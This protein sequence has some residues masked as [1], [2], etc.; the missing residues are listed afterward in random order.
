M[1]LLSV[2]FALYCV[3]KQEGKERKKQEKEEVGF[4]EEQE[5]FTLDSSRVPLLLFEEK[6]KELTE[7]SLSLGSLDLYNIL[8][9]LQVFWGSL[10]ASPADRLSAFP[11]LAKCVNKYPNNSKLETLLREG[12]GE[13]LPQ[14]G[15]ETE[16]EVRAAI[17]ELQGS[18]W[19][20]AFQTLSG[21]LLQ[22]IT[23]PTP[24]LSDQET[25]CVV[26]DILKQRKEHRLVGLLSQMTQQCQLATP[27]HRL[28]KHSCLSQLKK[29]SLY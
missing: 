2:A 8:Q 15:T 26:L 29:T 28:V 24:S 4:L 23:R 22:T 10:S 7:S 19:E 21:F 20:L 9:E 17:E 13:F 16:K 6:V 18:P 5:S 1:S 3:Q 25:V 27:F 14:L 12:L 11:L